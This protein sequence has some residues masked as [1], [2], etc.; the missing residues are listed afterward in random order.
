L[1]VWFEEN[2]GNEEVF[3]KSEKILHEIIECNFELYISKL[4]LSELSKKMDITQDIIL[5]ELLLPFRMLDKLKFLKVSKKIADD[6]VYFSSAYGVHK[7]DALHAMLAS[8]NNCI[9]VTRD[10]E[11]YRASNIYGTNCK[12]P[13]EIIP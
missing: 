5:D 9:L 1:N 7:A 8:S 3:F 13:E 6:A 2:V 10:R 12:Y 11:L 4:T